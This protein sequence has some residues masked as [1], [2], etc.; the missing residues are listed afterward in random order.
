MTLAIPPSVLLVDATPV[1]AEALQAILHENGFHVSKSVSGSERALAE[2]RQN[3]P[4][5]VCVELADLD[6]AEMGQLSA[7]HE[8]FPGLPLV[9]VTGNADRELI[10]QAIA[11]GA[12][13]LILVPFA[14]AEVQATFA[15]VRKRLRPAVP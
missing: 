1:S 12:S 10:K 14:A 6:A 3:R 4:D 9:V 2:M 11:R 8:E 7:M 5:I 15:R 13:G